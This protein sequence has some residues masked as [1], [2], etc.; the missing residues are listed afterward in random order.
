LGHQQSPGAE[1]QMLEALPW[2]LRH[3]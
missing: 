3:W 1:E 2:G